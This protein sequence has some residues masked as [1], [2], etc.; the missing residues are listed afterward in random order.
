M[1]PTKQ[2]IDTLLRQNDLPINIEDQQPAIGQRCNVYDII[3][4]IWCYAYWERDSKFRVY[5]EGVGRIIRVR[6]W[7]PELPKPE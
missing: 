7:L 5:N 3:D 2:F 4:K 1:N 6:C